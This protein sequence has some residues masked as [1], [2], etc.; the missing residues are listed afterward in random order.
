[1]SACVLLAPPL[2]MVAGLT[3]FG[4][5]LQS[6][7]QAV[8]AADGADART[9]SIF[10]RPDMAPG[11]SFMVASAEGAASRS[12]APIPN[13]ETTPSTSFDLQH[14]H[15][16][17]MPSSSGMRLASLEI[18]V[19]SGFPAE[20]IAPP[21]F[22]RPRASPGRPLLDER[23]DSFDE[24][25]GGAVA[26]AGESTTRDVGHRQVAHDVA[27]AGGHSFSGL[28]SYYSEGR[29]LASGGSFNSSE[30]TCA[31]PTLPFGTRLHVADPKSGRSV[32]VTV[33]DRGPF[34]RGRVLDLSLGAARA[35]GMIGR[36]V[37]RVEASVI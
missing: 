5:P 11:T 22:A 7:P 17:Q 13:D 21:A 30:Y 27:Q 1:V 2:L 14:P 31:H 15:G 18:P 4:S 36:G 37:M 19:N 10:G 12:G 25:F 34:V 23:L 29:H 6:A 33:N 32:V 28:A 20:D 24:R 3:Y 9:N 35:L 16:S 26:S 8:D